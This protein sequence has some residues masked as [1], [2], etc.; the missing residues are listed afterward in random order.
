[1]HVSAVA[2]MILKQPCLLLA[3]HITPFVF[4]LYTK[5]EYMIDHI[6]IK[7]VNGKEIKILSVCNGYAFSPKLTII[8]SMMSM[9]F[10]IAL[11]VWKCQWISNFWYICSVGVVALLLFFFLG[12][13]GYK[14]VDGF[15]KDQQLYKCMEHNIK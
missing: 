6:P 5:N 11:F 9:V 2:Q 1:M 15:D 14:M 12:V 4:T 13:L 7:M 10:T 3:P 8:N